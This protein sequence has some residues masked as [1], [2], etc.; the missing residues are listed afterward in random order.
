V[1]VGQRVGD[2]AAGD[3]V[4]AVL[5]HDVDQLGSLAALLPPPGGRLHAGA[6]GVG[7]EVAALAAAAAPAAVLD[8]RVTDLAR[9][10]A[11]LAQVAVQYQSAPDARAHQDPEQVLIGPAGSPP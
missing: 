3:A 9:R 8:R 1:V 2:H 7:L 6:A 5:A 11:P 10:P 4:A